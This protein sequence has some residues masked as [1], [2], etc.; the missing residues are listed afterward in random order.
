MKR[1]STP[2]KACPWNAMFSLAPNLVWSWA[3]PRNAEAPRSGGPNAL[4]GRGGTIMKTR[5]KEKKQGKLHELKGTA[6]EKAGQIA[7]NPDLTAEGV[8]EKVGGKV[9]KKVGQIEKVFEK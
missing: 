4:A 8:D 5:T 2:G 6:K 9:Q 3:N 1:G 7:N